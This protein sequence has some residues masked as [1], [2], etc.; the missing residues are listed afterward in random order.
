MS[1]DSHKPPRSPHLKV[2]RSCTRQS[3]GGK[4]PLF[5]HY[6]LSNC[7]CRQC[8]TSFCNRVHAHTET[9]LSGQKPSH[10]LAKQRHPK[11]AS[12]QPSQ[13]IVPRSSSALLR[14][15]INSSTD[16]IRNMYTTYLFQYQTV[17]QRDLIR[18]HIGPRVPP[19][20]QTRQGTRHHT[21]SQG[22]SSRRT[23][24]LRTDPGFVVGRQAQR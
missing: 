13:R 1:I 11:H 9:S 17:G 2:S 12:K 7:P 8:H 4:F 14:R 20:G 5:E 23:H 6:P 19:S 18:E 21:L 15:R 22:K 16:Q 3:D 10:P 24:F